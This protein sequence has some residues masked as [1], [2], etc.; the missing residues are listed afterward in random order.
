MKD[1]IEDIKLSIVVAQ[2]NSWKDI[3]EMQT[4]KLA[5]R[6]K[7]KKEQVSGTT[8]TKVVKAVATDRHRLQ[9][10]HETK[11][12]QLEDEKEKLE[13]KKKKGGEEEEKA[14]EKE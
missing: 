9:T 5:E 4:T 7:P 10:K 2:K 11:M 1:E 3:E 13:E 6:M 14:K 8:E 12:R